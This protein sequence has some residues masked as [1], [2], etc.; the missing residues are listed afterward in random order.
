MTLSEE[1]TM[2]FYIAGI[3]FDNSFKSNGSSQNTDPKEMCAYLI[4][5]LPQIIHDAKKEAGNATVVIAL[6]EYALTPQAISK[7]EKNKLLKLLQAAIKPYDNV[8]LVPGS[9]TYTHQ[10]NKKREKK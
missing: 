2:S 9:I 7:K 8:I 6:E 3:T 1:K 5:L 10:L 4:K